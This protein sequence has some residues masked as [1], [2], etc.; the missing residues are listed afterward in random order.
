MDF[1]NPSYYLYFLP[2]VFVLTIGLASKRKRTQMLILLTLSYTFF[3]LAS[4]WHLILLILSTCID[5]T[6]GKKMHQSNLETIRK[7]WLKLSLIL[8]EEDP[9]DS[10]PVN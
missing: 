10:S 7:N 2:L 9:T 3:W 5:W 4:G 6:A 1:V 8:L